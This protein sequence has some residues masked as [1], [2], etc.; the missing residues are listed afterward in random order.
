MIKQ[1]QLRGISR[2]PSDRLS[3]DGGLSESLNMYLDTAENA[4]AFLPDDITE[5]LG[6]PADLQADRIFIHKTANY[7][8]YIVVNGNKVTAYTAA[9]KKPL[10]VL[11]IE[12]GEKI[13]D[14]TSVGNTL[15]VA[16]TSG[17]AYA[18]FKEDSYDFIGNE[19]PFPTIEFFDAEVKA[20]KKNFIGNDN[21]EQDIVY[22]YDLDIFDEDGAYVV[23]GYIKNID[24]EQFDNAYGATFFKESFWNEL[25]ANNNHKNHYAAQLFDSVKAKWQEMIS[26][27]AEK[28]IFCSPFWAIYG[29]RLYD[30]SLVVST[31]QLVS[32][33][34]ACP[35]DVCG[36]GNWLSHNDNGGYD[37]FSN[38]LIRLNTFFRLGI[39]LY[40]FEDSKISS[41]S[42]IIK[43][44]DVFISEDI[45]NMDFSSMTLT[46]AATAVDD[47]QSLATFKLNKSSDESFISTALSK[48]SFVKVEEFSITRD[49]DTY[50]THTIASLRNDYVCDA[51]NYVSNTERFSGRELLSSQVFDMRQ[52]SHTSENHIIF[53]Q[54]LYKLGAKEILSSGPKWFCAQRFNVY[55]P[56]PLFAKF[57]LRATYPQGWF[58][59][60]W[61]S[62]ED[63]NIG[64]YLKNPPEITM[65]I[66]YSISE[67]GGS[68]FVYGKSI[69]EQ[70]EFQVIYDRYQLNK[71]SVESLV[72]YPNTDC[73]FVE[74]EVAS[75]DNTY[76]KRINM[77][78]HPYLP[79][80]YW[81]SNESLR[82]VV[83]N[84]NDF[85]EFKE[86]QK[87]IDYGNRLA[88]SPAENPFLL[89][90]EDSYT[91]QSKIL[92]AAIAS[93]ALSQ[94]QF[95]QFP[96]YVF[97]EDGIW[98]ME[99]AADGSFVTS[100]PLSREVCANP[101]SITSIDNAVV[102]VTEKAV[103]LIQG[104][105]VANI[106]PFMNGRH[107]TPNESA[108]S[109]IRKQ[110]GFGEFENVIKDETPF[111]SF[112]KK[113][114]IA[115]DYAGQRLICIAE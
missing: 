10:D 110:E 71:P 70:N 93:T 105:E 54:R 101:A 72:F 75:N 74:V 44:I 11:T 40:D 27:N 49:N 99:T 95:G 19:I 106:S 76:R 4:P 3:E 55:L 88:S 67:I 50:D 51:K 48:S 59:N 17:N 1:I 66:A 41:W 61:R 52:S 57:P 46:Q 86:E 78:P 68:A 42:D 109:L 13:N 38:F 91:F 85:Q 62:G 90:K 97:T 56:R 9:S 63:V 107:Y 35:I 83:I 102:F 34:E 20:I 103:M 58:S 79:C 45:Q 30:G 108:L 77:T 47:T 5:K 6:L 60:P 24:G 115:Y 36:Y 87:T 92:G 29:L 112:M 22:A 31:P 8:N 26:K 94:G 98:A 33:G 43:S 15:I 7:E 113:A 65:K 28:G 53:N 80:S 14:I 39:H 82:N 18:L 104:S 25:D 100:K 96:L 37:G 111:M 81:Y 84:T 21:F 114:S 73:K 23:D 32:P 12:E 16:T 69:D 2:T 64:G 89:I